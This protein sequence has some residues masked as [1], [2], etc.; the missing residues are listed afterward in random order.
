MATSETLHP[1]LFVEEGLGLMLLTITM[2]QSSAFTCSFSPYQRQFK[3][4]KMFGGNK[5]GQSWI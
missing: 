3:E 1:Q 2:P 5:I 4:E